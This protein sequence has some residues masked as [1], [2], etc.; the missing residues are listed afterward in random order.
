MEGLI[1]G[2]ADH[3]KVQIDQ[4]HEIFEKDGEE[5]CDFHLKFS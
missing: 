5:F 2:V 1:Q 4:T 3:F